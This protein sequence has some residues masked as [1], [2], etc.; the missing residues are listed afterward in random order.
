MLPICDTIPSRRFPLAMWSL[1]GLNTVVFFLEQT[2]RP[3][4]LEKLFWLYGI[5]PA[6]T[7]ALIREGAWPELLQELYCFVTSMFLHG[8]WLHFL[9]NMWVLY[10]FGDNVEDRMGPVRFLLFYLVCGLVAGWVHVLFNPTSE[11]PT[12]GASGAISG[13]MAAYLLLFPNA[14]VITLIPIFI[15]PWFVP[16]PAVLFIA[17]WY[18]TQLFEGVLSLSED[19]AFSGVAW[20]AHIGG[21][22]AGLTLAPLFARRPHRKRY[23]DEYAPW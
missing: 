23:A 14:T 7:T 3:A 11:V 9:S 15:F 1:I 17:L 10:L 21:F 6:Y 2:L 20:W 19:V 18:F 12:I 8:G 13:V 5:N 22:L 16:L 4:E